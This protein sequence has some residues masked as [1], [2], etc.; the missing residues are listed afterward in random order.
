[1]GGNVL[2]LTTLNAPDRSHDGAEGGRRAHLRIGSDHSIHLP[3][4]FDH[5]IEVIWG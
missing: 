3:I 5:E 4:S 1:V 2:T